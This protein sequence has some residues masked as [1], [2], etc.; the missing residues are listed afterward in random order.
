MEFVF[1]A[2]QID[3]SVM[4]V[5]RHVERLCFF[6]ILDRLKKQLTRI[7]ADCDTKQK[8]AII[9]KIV[10]LFNLSALVWT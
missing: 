10:L 6:S 5:R 2:G 9:S 4:F 1:R 3:N 8:D 7:L